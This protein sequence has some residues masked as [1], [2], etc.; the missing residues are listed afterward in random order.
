MSHWSRS[1]EFGSDR[2][3]KPD[4]GAMIAKSLVACLTVRRSGCSV[5]MREGSWKRVW[6]V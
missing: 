1:S 2:R 4:V 6:F 3:R 5:S